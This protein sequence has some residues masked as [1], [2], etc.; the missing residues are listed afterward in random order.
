VPAH[1]SLRGQSLAVWLEGSEL[2]RWPVGPGSFEIA[3]DLP[4][5]AGR[6]V[7]FEVR[8]TRWRRTPL[9]AG[10]GLHGVAWK[11]ESI[12]SERV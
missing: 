11:V 1:P 6:A 12:R 7:P 5:F 3:F 9:E 10:L 4:A 2:A 8:A